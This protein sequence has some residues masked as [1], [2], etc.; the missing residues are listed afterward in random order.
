MYTCI[1][2]IHS[3][4]IYSLH[5]YSALLCG[6]GKNHEKPRHSTQWMLVIMRKLGYTVCFVVSFF[7]EMARY[8]EHASPRLFDFSQLYHSC[9]FFSREWTIQWDEFKNIIKESS[10]QLW[11]SNVLSFF[12]SETAGIRWHPDK[13]LQYRAHLMIFVLHKHE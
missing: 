3:F 6:G 10:Y 4:F 13:D 1:E 9:W 5:F 7:Y 2:V 11:K 12:L 8:Q